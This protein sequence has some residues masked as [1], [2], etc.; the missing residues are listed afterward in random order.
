MLNRTLIET[1][2]FTLDFNRVDNRKVLEMLEGMSDEVQE[3]FIFRHKRKL[4]F[5]YLFENVAMCFEADNSRL[6]LKSFEPNDSYEFPWKYIAK[7][8]ELNAIKAF[9]GSKASLYRALC[10][11]AERRQNG[12]AENPL[13]SEID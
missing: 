1:N 2:G 10:A 6:V 3:P 8:Y 11:N 7:Q 5:V 12:E 4:V 9:S 13:H